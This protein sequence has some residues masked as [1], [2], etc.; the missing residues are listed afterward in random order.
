MELQIAWKFKAFV[1]VIPSGMT[2]AQLRTVRGWGWRRSIVFYSPVQLQDQG[3]GAGYA[4]F[5]TQV[6]IKCGLC[7][8]VKKWA[9]FKS[10]QGEQCGSTGFLCPQ[11]HDMTSTII[12]SAVGLRMEQDRRDANSADCSSKLSLLSATCLLIFNPT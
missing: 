2:V 3:L 8:S 7:E 4:I 10:N 5:G 12:N 1:S 6:G 9:R 11:L